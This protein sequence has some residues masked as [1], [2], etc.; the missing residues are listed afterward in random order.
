MVKKIKSKYQSL[1]MATKATLWAFVASMIQ[2]GI[3]IISTPIF[4]RILSSE[5][6]AQYTIYQSWHEIFIIFVSLNVFNYATYT[7]LTKYSDDRDNFISS[8]QSVISVLSIVGFILYSIIHLFFIKIID[9]SF[10]VIVVMFLDMLFFSSFSLWAAKER[11]NF[12][13]KLV[14]IYSII[15]GFVGPIL[16]IILI[17]I[18]PNNN[19]IARIYGT[20]FINIAIGIICF[21]M[22]YR[23]STKILKNEYSK[24]IFAYCVPLIPHFLS[25]QILTRFDR[26]MINDI[27]GAS[28]AGIYSLAYSLSSLLL[29][30]NEAIFK[31]LTPLTYKTIKENN[32]IIKLK[33]NVTGI[34]LLIAV[35]NFLLILF[36]PEAVKIFAPSEYY[37]AIYIIPSVSASVYLTYLFNLFANIEYYYS[38]TKFVTFASIMSAVA[39][40]VLNFIFINK[41]GYIAAGYTTLVSYI[42]YAIGHYIFMCKVLK[43]HNIKDSYYDDKAIIY[44]SIIFIIATIII[45]PLYNLLAI[46]YLLIL[47]LLICLFLNKSKIIIFLKKS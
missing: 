40:V 31:S 29:I 14:T 15:I 4:T 21:F 23:K 36:A 38:E 3:S 44:I 22:N 5:Q 37:E 1:S 10:S 42:L 8:A 17:Y 25:T 18:M 43:K 13:Y 2:K 27:C 19:G 26:I 46:R 6:Y 32:D 28:K 7:G 16:S 24:F 47:I 35:L 11:M 30:V 39:N 34:T 45:I 41:Y 12:K 9:F 33:K 20:A